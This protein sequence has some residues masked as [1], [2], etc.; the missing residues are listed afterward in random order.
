MPLTTKA[1]AALHARA[2]LG[3]Q[4]DLEF[5]PLIERQ[6]GVDRELDRG[7]VVVAGADHREGAA[8]TARGPPIR[9][10]AAAL[11]QKRAMVTKPPLPSPATVAAGK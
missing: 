9:Y 4:S 8:R 7:A 6:G 1:K 3:V 5:D 11:A 10:P 2:G